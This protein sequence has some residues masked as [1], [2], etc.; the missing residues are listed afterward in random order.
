MREFLQALFIAKRVY[1]IA[2]DKWIKEQLCDMLK[3]PE[4]YSELVRIMEYEKFE[5]SEHIGKAER[6]ETLVNQL[7]EE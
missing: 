2:Y 7:C 4:L 3:M 5:S 1:P 6:L